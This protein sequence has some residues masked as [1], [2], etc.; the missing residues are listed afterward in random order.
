MAPPARGVAHHP[1]AALDMN[2][3]PQV[4]DDPPAA[5]DLD[6][7]PSHTPSHTAP[8]RRTIAPAPD[9]P[10][11][12]ARAA[13][14]TGFL[15][16]VGREQVPVWVFPPDR[17]RHAH[18]GLV[19]RAGA[20]ELLVFTGPALDWGCGGLRLHVLD[21]LAPDSV[22]ST[23]ST[24]STEVRRLWRRT[25]SHSGDLQGLVFREPDSLIARQLHAFRPDPAA[26]RWVR[27]MIEVEA[28]V[29]VEVEVG[30]GPA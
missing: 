8:H 16:P 4:P 28:E 7:P 20:R 27:C 13:R 23:G 9:R 29:E 10:A 14:S 18:A 17:L 24:G 19:L 12:P 2:A 30:A 5:D 6:T 21:A 1:P 11:T 26:H 22:G 25:V 3:L 15:V